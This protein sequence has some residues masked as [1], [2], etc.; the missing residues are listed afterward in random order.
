MNRRADQHARIVRTGGKHGFDH[1]ERQADDRAGNG[2]RRRDDGR[3]P[4]E[5]VGHW[6]AIGRR[7]HHDIVAAD[8]MMDPVHGSVVDIAMRHG[9]GRR[10]AIGCGKKRHACDGLRQFRCAVLHFYRLLTYRKRTAEPQIRQLLG[11]PLARKRRPA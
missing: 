1:P 2:D 3:G 10:Q 7:S 4:M 11:L 5:S 8:R 9:R 6:L